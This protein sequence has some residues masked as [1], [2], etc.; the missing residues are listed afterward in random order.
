MPFFSMQTYILV[1]NDQKEV[2][3]KQAEVASPVYLF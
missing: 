1:T 2:I 3:M